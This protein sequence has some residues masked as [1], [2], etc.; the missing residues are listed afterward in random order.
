MSSV[1]VLIFHRPPSSDDG[2]FTRALA[3]VR[4]RLLAAHEAMFVAGGAAEIRVI[5]EWRAGKT[6][7][8]VL[9][10]EAPARGGLV[11]LS[12][13]AVPLLR[14][15]DAQR[16]VTVAGGRGRQALTNNRY[17]SDICAVSDAATLHELPPLPSDNALPRWLEER[18]GYTVDEL[19]ARDRLALDLDTPLDVA[20]AA[21]ARSC[22]TWLREAAQ[23][24]GFAVPRRD[25][26]RALAA[27][28]H[29]ELLVFGRAGS[30][31]LRWLER[32]V[33]CRVRFLAEERGMRAASPLAIGDPAAT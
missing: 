24:N 30:R 10:N 21:L 15:A 8:E 23:H 3:E 25:E 6:F 29:G 33:R 1:T 28:P 27:N 12:S 19:A 16:L 11:V 2:P 9:A 14:L 22:P 5:A 13:G 32:N 20:I 4:E 18:A 17:S 31:T 7:G 26:I